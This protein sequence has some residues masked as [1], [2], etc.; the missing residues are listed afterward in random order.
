MKRTIARA[1]APVAVVLIIGIAIGLGMLVAVAPDVIPTVELES[2]GIN[3]LWEDGSF[4]VSPLDKISIT[5]C[6]PLH[7]WNGEIVLGWCMDGGTSP[8]GYFERD[9]WIWTIG[10][11]SPWEDFM[12]E[13]FSD[14]M[15]R[16]VSIYK[17]AR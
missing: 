2:R 17:F 16:L 1:I 6:L 12:P 11:D 3:R 14:M 8:L 4:I 13:P 9:A 7:P 5:G 15:Y 10:I